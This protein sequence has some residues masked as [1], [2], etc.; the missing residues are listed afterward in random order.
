MT[1]T[2][3]GSKP[4]NLITRVG[5]APIQDE[6]NVE[7]G[8][9]MYPGRLV[10]IGTTEDD[11]LVGDALSPQLGWL[12]YEDTAIYYRPATP[13]TA[14]ATG[15]RAMVLRGGKFVVV[16][17]VAKGCV[18]PFGGMVAG[19]ASGQLVGPVL[20]SPGGVMLGVPFTKATTEQTTYIE[21]PADMVVNPNGI[22]VDV[23]TAAGGST[24]DV[25]LG[26]AAPVEAGGDADGFLDGVSCA[27]ALKVGPIL[28]HGTE[29][30]MTLGALLRQNLKD[31]TTSP[32]FFQLPKLHR[33]DGTAK[34]VT[35]TTSNHTV[36]G[37]IWLPLMAE[38]LEIV[39]KVQENVNTTAAA[40][41]AFVLSRI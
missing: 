39:G 41:S 28:S 34:T 16:G 2:K 24:I 33:C 35:Y 12:G 21:L 36:A 1:Y 8:T 22:V 30:S 4:N 10:K 23:A 19:W 29:G 11:V 40:A 37:R 26:E 27:S 7:S 14:Y 32:L 25:G 31:A 15:D 38:G 13:T 18:I 20:P 17:S 3:L 5:R 6:F 9:D